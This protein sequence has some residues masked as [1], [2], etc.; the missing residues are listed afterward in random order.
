MSS[1]YSTVMFIY[2]VSAKIICINMHPHRNQ[3]QPPAFALKCA[4]HWPSAENVT[5]EVRTRIVPDV[6]AG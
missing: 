3:P 5:I 2:K 1:V 6:F 4:L